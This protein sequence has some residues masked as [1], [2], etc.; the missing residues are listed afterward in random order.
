[1]LGVWCLIIMFCIPLLMAL[2]DMGEEKE[3]EKKPELSNEMKEIVR[4]YLAEWSRY[5]RETHSKL[6]FPEYMELF[7][8]KEKEDK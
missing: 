2:S 5:R 1:M 7:H 3:E 8:G 6:T 4:E